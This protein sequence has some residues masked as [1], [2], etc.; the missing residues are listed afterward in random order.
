MTI[1]SLV[2]TNPTLLRI[3]VWLAL[4]LELK[5]SSL[6]IVDENQM[7][8]PLQ[9]PLSASSPL[10][11]TRQPTCTHIFCQIKQNSSAS[12]AN[13]TDFVALSNP[14]RSS[15]WAIKAF[16]VAVSHYFAS[17][18]KGTLWRINIFGAQ[19]DREAINNVLVD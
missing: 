16:I 3:W 13:N 10:P 2:F 5:A 12:R 8:Q 4:M 18:R 11:L 1:S 19:A 7:C 15:D 17:C 14:I 6:Q 9:N